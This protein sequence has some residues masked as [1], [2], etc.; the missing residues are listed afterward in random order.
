[1]I[2]KIINNIINSN[3]ATLFEAKD[4]VINI[5]KKRAEEEINSNIPSP[6]TF[7][8]QLKSLQTSS[9]VQDNLL[10]VEKIYNTSI[11]LIDKVIK[12]SEDAQN[13]LK[14]VKA[15]FT[16]ITQKINKLTEYIEILDPLFLILNG[17]I[18]TIDGFLAT[19]SSTFANGL[20]INRL[21]EKKKDL[22]DLIK[23]G[24]D[25][26]SSTDDISNFFNKEK[27]KFEG[28]VDKGI[29]SLEE[30]INSLGGPLSLENPPLGSIKAEIIRIYQEF[31]LSLIIPE[32]NDE[33]NNNEIL[34]NENLLDYIKDENNLNTII[35]D[36]VGAGGE[37]N[38]GNTLEESITQ[39][40]FKKFKQ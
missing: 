30:L 8:A 40:A 37:N 2:N 5:A 31:I 32:L 19:S 36:V 13:E 16:K 35:S 38:L 18:P 26:V 14:S 4:K 39:L 3:T 33:D 24:K 7:E 15:K 11:N 23:K 9:N 25:C 21:G 1:M 12:R 6:A 22:K 20:L 10:K 27:E 34:G 28:P 17:L 29:S